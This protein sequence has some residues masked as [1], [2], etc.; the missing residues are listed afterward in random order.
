LASLFP[1]GTVTKE[2]AE[3][4]NQMKTAG[5]LIEEDTKNSVVEDLVKDI[6]KSYAHNPNSKSLIAVDS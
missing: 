2:I 3:R 5:G 1:N 4:L 6:L